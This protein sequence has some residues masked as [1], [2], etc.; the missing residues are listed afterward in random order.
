MP[1]IKDWQR[2]QTI[3]TKY[4][5]E[6]PKWWLTFNEIDC[7]IITVLKLWNYHQLAYTAGEWG[8]TLMRTECRSEW[9]HLQLLSKA[10]FQ[11]AAHPEH[12]ICMTS[13]FYE[14]KHTLFLTAYW[15]IWW[16]ASI[17]FH[18]SIGQI[19]DGLFM[20]MTGCLPTV[21]ASYYMHCC[22]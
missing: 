16:M 10:C 9:T 11:K 5:S 2:Y 20:N 12:S 1:L 13:R 22:W 7:Q 8:Q 4:C 21:N 19:S 17:V 6:P 3:I 15:V 14:I 18:V